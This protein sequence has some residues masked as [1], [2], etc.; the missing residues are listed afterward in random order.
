MQDSSSA[1]STYLQPKAYLEQIPADVWH[2][3]LA[4]FC[5]HC[6]RENVGCAPQVFFDRP[7]DPSGF[8]DALCHDCQ[9]ELENPRDGHLCKSHSLGYR[10]YRANKTTLW[11]LSLTSRTLR[12]AAQPV[13]YHLYVPD[14][15]Y[16][17]LFRF[18]GS[19]TKNNHL[20]CFVKSLALGRVTNH[21]RAM[22]WHCSLTSPSAMNLRAFTFPPCGP[23]SLKFSDMSLF[24][25]FIRLFPALSNLS[26]NEGRDFSSLDYVPASLQQPRE[27]P[28]RS[29]QLV[30]VGEG[31]STY[32][33]PSRLSR[34]AARIVELST[35][36]QVLK[37]HLCV[38]LIAPGLSL[39]QL[40]VLH[41]TESWL[42]AERVR[43]ILNACTALREFVYETAFLHL[44]PPRERPT[45]ELTFLSP[46][47]CIRALER[48]KTTLRTLE[49][50]FYDS[51]AASRFASSS[52]ITTLA[53][54]SNLQ[55]L[56]LEWHVI[57][58]NNGE[59][60][61]ESLFETQASDSC[62]LTDLLPKCIQSLVIINC[63]HG[64]PPER[65]QQ[66][67]EGLALAKAD[68]HFIN[69][70]RIGCDIIRVYGEWKYRKH[71]WEL[72]LSSIKN[73]FRTSGVQVD[74]RL[75]WECRARGSMW[76]FWSKAGHYDY[77]F[78]DGLRC[79]LN[80][81][82]RGPPMPLPEWDDDD[83]L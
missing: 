68:G 7:A 72:E 55:N 4:H 67:L 45:P 39:S 49:L 3:I 61:A 29:I 66:A 41:I 58:G 83:D 44:G 71:P 60:S 1:M 27:L 20:A 59:D 74:F 63:V 26:L 34:M 6:C 30:G 28:L 42:E 33:R 70:Q 5:Q 25:N 81:D 21:D 78:D 57:C 12:R 16:S 2:L 73:R 9:L 50:S 36:L 62:L 35:N 15:D 17:Q 82:F 10:K 77:V 38:D 52:G 51:L 48:F 54:F 56:L 53:N 46:S 31:R 40:Q 11:S 79:C 19:V 64:Y 65:L 75:E 14:G 18:I 22:S 23:E 47:D 32:E 13:M 24:A 37:L 69:L 43:Y 8:P 80:R 76:P